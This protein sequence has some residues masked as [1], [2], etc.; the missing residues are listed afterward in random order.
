MSL[1]PVITPADKHG[2]VVAVFTYECGHSDGLYFG[3]REFVRRP[4]TD[5]C[6]NCQN[7]RELARYQASS[8]IIH[9]LPA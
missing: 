2:G 5:C 4:P 8:K 6:L 9:A 1:D 3:G 7:S